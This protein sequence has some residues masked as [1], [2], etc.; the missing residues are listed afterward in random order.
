[1]ISQKINFRIQ[2]RMRRIIIS[3]HVIN[4]IQY[5]CM[6]CFMWHFLLITIPNIFCL[7]RSIVVCA[8]LHT[9]ARVCVCVR[10]V[11]VINYDF[12]YQRLFFPRHWW[13]S[14]VWVSVS[15]MWKIKQHFDISQNGT[16]SRNFRLL[17]L[18]LI[19]YCH[20]CYILKRPL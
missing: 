4:K 17:S 18:I 20:M 14:V 12:C 7:G 6:T 3:Q 13:Q 11:T 19:K 1:M 9:H 16:C 15:L 10:S 5:D 2:T 8:C